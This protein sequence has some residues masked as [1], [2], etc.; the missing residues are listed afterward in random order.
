ML[1]PSPTVSEQ[2]RRLLTTAVC[3]EVIPFALIEMVG[4]APP[5]EASGEVAPTEVTV[6]VPAQCAV[7]PE[8]LP[9][10]RPVAVSMK[11]VEE[12]AGGVLAAAAVSVTICH[13]DPAEPQ[14][15]MTKESV[16]SNPIPQLPEFAALRQ[17]N[18]SPLAKRPMPASAGFVVVEMNGATA[19]TDCQF[20]LEV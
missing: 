12:P 3:A 14:G 9:Q 1:V 19:P 17:L 16:E 6:P 7:P 5:E 4:V 2:A 10:G 15:S 13:S 8:S 20:V 18:R 11:K